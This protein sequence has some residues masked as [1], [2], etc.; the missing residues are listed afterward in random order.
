M[1]A[2]GR[3]ETVKQVAE[4]VFD[5]IQWYFEKVPTWIVNGLSTMAAFVGGVEG[6]TDAVL[7]SFQ[8]MLD[9]ASKAFGWMPGDRAQ[10]RPGR[11]PLPR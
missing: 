10:A 4:T 7:D 2:K 3:W 11:K 1:L 5:A 6:I 9:G 8:T